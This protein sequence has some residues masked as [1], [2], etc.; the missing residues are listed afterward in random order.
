MDRFSKE[1][2]KA[3]MT[4]SGEQCVSFYLPTHRTPP[5]AIQDPIRL[6]NMKKAAEVRLIQG[7]LRAAEAKE[8][9]APVKK[10]D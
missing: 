2:L 7:G 6:R 1:E 10:C 8:F 3:L 9:L 4:P 5:D